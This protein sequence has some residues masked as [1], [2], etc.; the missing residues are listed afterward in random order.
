MEKEKSFIFNK[1]T[2]EIN[3]RNSKIQNLQVEIDS[4]NSRLK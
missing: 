4:L 2:N 1:Y 3:E